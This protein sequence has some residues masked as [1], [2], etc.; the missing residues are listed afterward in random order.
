MASQGPLYIGFDL[1]TQQL[2]GLVVNSELKVIH[3]AKFDFDAD[4]I[5]F[6]VRKGVIVNEVKHEVFAPVALWLQALDAVLEDLRQQGLDFRLVKGISAAGQQHGSVYWSE[7]A[8]ELLKTLNPT[9]SLEEQ[10]QGA[11]SH[12]YSPNWQDSSTQNECNQ[13]EE[14]LGGPEELASAT[15]SRAH[16]VRNRDEMRKLEKSA[17]QFPEIHRSPD[18]P[19]LPLIPRGI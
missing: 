9:K 12:P 5:G 7:D 6:Q 17:D 8:E 4:S 16:H 14:I 10:L 15:G 18:P 3:V 13:F 19:L 11:F 1:S 2:K